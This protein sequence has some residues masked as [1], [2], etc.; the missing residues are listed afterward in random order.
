[1][2][3]N[4]FMLRHAPLWVPDLATLI[5]YYEAILACLAILVRHAHRTV[6]DS[7]VYQQYET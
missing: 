6:F 7:A 2:V 4:N 5:H 3:F 1:M